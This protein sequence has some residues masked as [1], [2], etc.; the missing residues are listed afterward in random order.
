MHEAAVI[1]C[2][3]MA[4][5]PLLEARG[6]IFSRLGRWCREK[7]TWGVRYP[8]YRGP[9]RST[10]WRRLYE[11]ARIAADSPRGR[12]ALSLAEFRG[13]DWPADAFAMRFVAA[14]SATLLDAG[15]PEELNK[16]RDEMVNEIHRGE[17]DEA[18][19][20]RHR[21]WQVTVRSAAAGAASGAVSYF[22]FHNNVQDVLALGVV[23]FGATAVADLAH[24]GFAGI[25]EEMLA[26]RRQVRDWLGTLSAWLAGYVVWAE[27][28]LR[29]REYSGVDELVY[30][31]TALASKDATIEPT[32]PDETILRHVTHLL[33]TADRVGDSDLKAA[34]L[35]IEGALRFRRDNL[36]DAIANIISLV[37]GVPDISGVNSIQALSAEYDARQISRRFLEEDRRE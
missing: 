9:G 4:E 8:D 32:P 10:F 30:V 25:S 1:L 31:L 28:A 29:R 3:I 22:A 7:I 5:T 15:I 24:G 14:T 26:A 6:G 34:L 36:P 20:K 35:N 12:Q 19:R 37:Q 17:S 21:A 18:M 23:G 27:G 2:E 13:G 16:L 33:E 11:W